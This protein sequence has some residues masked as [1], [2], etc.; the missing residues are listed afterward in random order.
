MLA[1]HWSADPLCRRRPA[2]GLAE[3]L[4]GIRLGRVCSSK[5]LLKF[6]AD[7]RNICACLRSLSLLWHSWGKPLI[8]GVGAVLVLVAPVSGSAFAPQMIATLDCLR[9]APSGTD[10]LS[11]RVRPPGFHL[12]FRRLFPSDLAD[13]NIFGIALGLSFSA[14]VHLATWAM[15]ANGGLTHSKR[16]LLV[17]VNMATYHVCVL[18]WFY[19]LLVPRQSCREVCG[20]SA[21][22]QSRRLEPGTGASGTPMTIAIILVV[23]AALALVFILRRHAVPQ[24]ADFR[25]RRPRPRKFS[26]LMSRPFAIS[27][28]PRKTTILRRRLPAAEFRLVRR[29]RLRAMAAYVQSGGKK[30]CHPGA[31]GTSRLDRRRRL[32][33]PRPRGNWWTMPCCFAATPLS[34]CSES[35]CLAWPNSGLAAAPRPSRLRAIE[36]LRHAA[37]QAAK[38]GRP[39]AHFSDVVIRCDRDLIRSSL[40]PLAFRSAAI[41]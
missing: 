19:Y 17:F 23:A 21:R 22:K 11:D 3:W 1:L 27:S 41:V 31:H 37:G 13:R 29:E 2:L 15:I 33:P 35:T 12:S 39:G 16:I 14:C 38:S 8:R 5:A 4:S 10:H 7:W 26:P 18:I 25:E 24:P 32:P 40:T 30:C 20:S 6:V 9:A 36:W 34:L 28:I